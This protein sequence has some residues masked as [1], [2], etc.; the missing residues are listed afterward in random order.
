M[1]VIVYLAKL[2]VDICI[3]ID[4]NTALHLAAQETDST[5]LKE[6]LSLKKINVDVQ[7]EKVMKFAHH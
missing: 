1:L 6:L 5:I 4:G 2:N 7:N 3:K